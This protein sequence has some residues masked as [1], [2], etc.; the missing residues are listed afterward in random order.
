MDSSV[1]NAN[2]AV[3]NFNRRIMNVNNSVTKLND[4][5]MWRQFNAGECDKMKH[6][7]KDNC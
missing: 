1:I 5:Y 7:H 2:S 4:N 3:N 6:W